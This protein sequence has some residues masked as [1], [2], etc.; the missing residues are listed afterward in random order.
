MDPKSKSSKQSKQSTQKNVLESL[1]DVGGQTGDTIKKDL[2]GATSR[3]F[4]Q[5]LLGT[6]RPQKVSGE[7]VPGE[8]L[9]MNDVFSGKHEENQKLK[10]QI[11]LEKRLRQEEKER[12]EKKAGELKLQLNALMQ[13][14]AALAEETGELAEETQIAT[15][16]AP[17]EPGIYHIIFF[18]KLLEFIKSFRKKIHEANVW[19]HATNKRAEKKNYWARYKKHGSKFLLSADHYLTRSAG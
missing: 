12:S 10:Q 4:I 15:M 17:V 3:D 1:K 5:Q 13:E 19:L 8:A 9:E 6:R 14:V 7:M 11:A 16:Q 18:E 2:V